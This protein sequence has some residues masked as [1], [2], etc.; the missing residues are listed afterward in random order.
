[1]D[2]TTRV[3]LVQNFLMTKEFPVSVGAKLLDIN[4]TSVYYKA[5]PASA[6]KLACKENIDHLLTDNPI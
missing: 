4:H 3:S 1:M 5:K 2:L 6:E